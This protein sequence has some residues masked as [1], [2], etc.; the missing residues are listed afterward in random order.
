[1]KTILFISPALQEVLSQK[2]DY[3]DAI[4]RFHDAGIMINGSF[5]LR[6][7]MNRS[8]LPATPGAQAGEA[9]QE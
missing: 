7:G 9:R 3:T 8:E 1:M 2:Y 6:K 4:K 5:V